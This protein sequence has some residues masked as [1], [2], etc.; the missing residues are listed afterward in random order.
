MKT[1]LYATDYSQN[2]VNA[3]IM[4]HTMAKKLNCKLIVMHVFDD[5]VALASSVSITYLKKEKKLFKEHATRLGN[6]YSEHLGIPINE[7]EVQIEVAE[8]DSA[9][10]GLLEGA[11]RFDADMLVL[12]TKGSSRFKEFFLGSTTKALI[13]KAPCPVM[14]VPHTYTSES[15]KTMIYATDFEEA[16]IFAIKKLTVLAKPFNAAIK[17]VHVTNKKEYAG[18]QQM[19]WFK[20]ILGQKVPTENME[21]EVVTSEEIFTALYAFVLKTGADVLVMLERGD[22]GFYRQLF[23]DDLVTTMESKIL[24]PL[25]S[26]NE[27]TL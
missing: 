6:F 25:L 4:A 24:V 21:F 20:E 11:T 27:T 13:K 7:T 9:V 22:K 18:D 3:L 15:I 23:H 19:E 1:I 16:D 12:G 17:V 10:A 14:A 2:S 5:P 26:F 8:N